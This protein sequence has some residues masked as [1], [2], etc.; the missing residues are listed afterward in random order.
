MQFA[1]NQSSYLAGVAAALTSRTGTIGFVGGM[2]AV[3][4]WAFHGGFQAGAQSVDPNIEVQFEYLADAGDYSG[5]VDAAGAEEAASRM[6]EAGA[7]VV[8]HAAGDAGVG[9]FEAATALSTDE[10]QLWAIGVDSDQYET[11]DMLPGAV[12]PDAWRRHI[13]TS[14]IKRFDIA[15]HDVIADF[16]QGGFIP[17]KLMYDLASRA[18][19]LSFSGGYMNDFFAE[20]SNA[21]RNA[22]Q[23]RHRH[24]AVLPDRTDGR[25]PLLRR[26][27]SRRPLLA[28]TLVGSL[29]SRANVEPASTRH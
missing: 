12:N 15:T 29:L 21:A 26:A 2:D 27:P 28:L 14:V 1:D 18:V 7:D 3:D 23:R 5:F 19:D 25:G 22:D 9:V 8:F 6:Y 20:R 11:V 10:R 4:I 13:L 17:G 16:T 24:R